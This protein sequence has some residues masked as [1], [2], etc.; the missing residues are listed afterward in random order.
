MLSLYNKKK[1][2]RCY[3]QKEVEINLLHSCAYVR[4]YPDKEPLLAYEKCN[5][6]FCMSFTFYGTFNGKVLQTNYL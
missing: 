1:Q 5:C 2:L 3:V 6:I 4:V